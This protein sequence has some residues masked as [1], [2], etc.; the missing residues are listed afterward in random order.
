M[1]GFKFTRREVYN[2]I[3]SCEI[4][5]NGWFF[6]AEYL[7]LGEKLGFIIREIPIRWRDDQDSRVSILKLSV[8]YL[9]EI[10]RLRLRKIH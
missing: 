5:N 8:Y 7:Y 6:C 4:R 9:Y 3:S 10:I 1:C 2:Y